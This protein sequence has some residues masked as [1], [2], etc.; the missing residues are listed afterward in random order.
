MAQVGTALT[1]TRAGAPV[2]MR[3][4]SGRMRQRGEAAARDGRGQLDLA[5][6]YPVVRRLVG[7]DSFEVVRH[8]FAGQTPRGLELSWEA[9]PD[10]LRSQGNGA[11]FDYLADIAGLELACAKARMAAAAKP[12]AGVTLAALLTGGP[13]RLRLTLHPSV[14]LVTSR[15][16]IVSIWKSNQRDGDGMIERWRAEAALVAR[17]FRTVEVRRLPPGGHAFIQ[18]L[19]QRQTVSA[20]VAAAAAVA[21]GFDADAG[22]AILTDVV[23][24]FRQET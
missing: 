23:V 19:A 7:E 8:R 3:S 12:L 24:G 18:A 15:F 5:T 14:H 20:A 21:S 9:F 17:P 4:T 22:R 1:Q 2:R 11:S 16:P 6:C 10:F 13:E